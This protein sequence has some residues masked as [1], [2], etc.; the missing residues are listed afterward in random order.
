MIV[1]EISLIVI[2]ILIVVVLANALLLKPTSARTAK[3]QVE[4][5]PRAEQY[6]K[7]LAR[8][9]QKETISGR[10]DEDRTKFLEFH[11]LLED[12][13]PEIHKSC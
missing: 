1:L 11:K 2:A 8:L 10:F 4:E 13:F 9:V 3:V 12:M 6:G 7:Q 5:G